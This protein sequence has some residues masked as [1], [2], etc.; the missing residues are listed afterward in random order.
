VNPDPPNGGSWTCSGDGT[1]TVIIRWQVGGWIDTLT[2][3]ASG[4]RLE[5]ENQRHTPVWGERRR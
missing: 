2:L 4:N 1:V 5:G 3:D